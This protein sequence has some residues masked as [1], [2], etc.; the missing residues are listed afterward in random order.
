M[1]QDQALTAN[2]AEPASSNGA[3]VPARKG[4]EIRLSFGFFYVV[5]KWGNERRS[6]TRIEQDRHAFPVLTATNLPV[7]A[8]VWAA[9]FM[10]LYAMLKMS[11]TAMVYLFS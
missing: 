6:G 7:L 2:S 1:S 4:G 10:L 3:D 5:L 11:I 9:L 8:A